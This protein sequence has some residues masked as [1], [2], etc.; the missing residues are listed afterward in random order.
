MQLLKRPVLPASLIL[1]L[2]SCVVCR[3]TAAEISYIT[4][5]AATISDYSQIPD[6]VAAAVNTIRSNVRTETHNINGERSMHIFFVS[7]SAQLLESLKYQLENMQASNPLSLLV[8]R[9]T[10]VYVTLAPTPSP[11]APPSSHDMQSTIVLPPPTPSSS[12]STSATVGIAIAAA[13]FVFAGVFL[14]SKSYIRYYEYKMKRKYGRQRRE[15]VGG[16]S[17]DDNDDEASNSNAYPPHAA[18]G[19]MFN[20]GAAPPSAKAGKGTGIK[21]RDQADIEDMDWS[22]AE[23]DMHHVAS[24]GE[25]GDAQRHHGGVTEQQRS[26]VSRE[27]RHPPVPQQMSQNTSVNRGA[28][29]RDKPRGTS[30]RRRIM[31]PP[32][33]SEVQPQEDERN[34]AFG[35]ADVS[36]AAFT[37]AAA[38]VFPSARESNTSSASPSYRQQ[39]NRT[40][41]TETSL[42]PKGATEASSMQ[43]QTQAQQLLD[44]QKST[45]ADE[46]EDN[47]DSDASTRE[48]DRNAL[49]DH[50]EF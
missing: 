41:A 7:N 12:L 15:A 24:P 40:Q 16:E 30:N 34:S 2:L 25:R 31:P 38:E 20:L 28:V 14:F 3:S 1:L 19:E 42:E 49:R 47:S 11:P 33:A 22:D 36:I 44:H 29:P 17:G 32:R 4:V 46:K 21:V 50:F 13:V 6:A 26:H 35:T 10:V 37:A 48:I 45:D 23:A 39:S 27:V 8:V 43:K 18:S 5:R 9:Y